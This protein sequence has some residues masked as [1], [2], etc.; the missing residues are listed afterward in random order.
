MLLK[1]RERDSLYNLTDLYL[2]NEIIKQKFLDCKVDV[3]CLNHRLKE[4]YELDRIETAAGDVRKTWNLYKDIL[5]NQQIKK[6]EETI[7]INGKPIDDLEDSCNKVNDHFCLAGER[8]ATD[9]VGTHGY[10]IE[11]I[12]NLYPDLANNN[13][14]FKEV[15]NDDVVRAIEKIPNKKSTG[16]DRVP[17]SL[18]KKTSL[19]IAPLIMLC[20]NLA[21]RTSTYPV[22]LLKGRLKLIHKSGDSDIDNFRGLTLLPSLSKIFEFLLSEQLT[23]YLESI[24]MFKGN[25]FGFIRQSS[26]LSAALQLVNFIKFHTMKQKYVACLFVDLKRAFDRD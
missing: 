8:L 12:D 14:S 25:Q 1:I 23:A 15:T 21:I 24:N 20:F 7:S 11:D 2:D 19:L 18:L 17:I 4:E 22:E 10:E 16:I 3:D 5:F 9:I 26:C 6:P 13:W